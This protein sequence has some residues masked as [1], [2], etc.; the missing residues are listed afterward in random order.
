IEDNEKKDEAEDN[1]LEKKLK[2]L[3]QQFQ[4]EE[5]QF[6]DIE[7]KC[8]G[9]ESDLKS[10]SLSQVEKGESIKRGNEKEANKPRQR[11]SAFATTN[12]KRCK[13]QGQ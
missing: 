11:N 2:M 1:P 6:K 7:K 3:K 5:D 9:Y 13:G 8:E 4:K 12:C 10:I